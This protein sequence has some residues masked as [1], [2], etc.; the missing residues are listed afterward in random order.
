VTQSDA[1]DAPPA[2]GDAVDR[3]LSATPIALV[4]M[5]GLFPQAH[6]VRDY[7]QNVVDATDCTS[8]VPADRWK[9]ED[10]WDPDPA[11][12]DKTYSRRG[13]FL[14]EVDFDPLEFGLPPN[15]LE[16]TSTLQTLSLGVARDVLCDAGAP[17]SSWYDPS[18]TGVVLGVTGPVPLMHPLAAR[19]ST[20]VLEEVV[21]SC[22]LTDDDAQTISAKYVKAFAPWVE[23][24]FPGLLA[25]VVAGRVANRLG[26]GGMNS[27]VDAACA[28][29][30]SAT[31]V[32]IAELVDR[33]AD[34]MITGGCD[35]ENSIFIYLCFSKVGAL[36]HHDRIRPFDTSADGTLLG[37][38]IGMLAL[39]RLADAERDGDRVY[40]VIRGLGSSS[41]GRATSIY[42]PRAEGQRLALDRAYADAD[43]SPASV[44][45]FEAHA[46]GTLV[47]DRTELTALGGLLR[48]H[49][50]EDRFAAIGSVKSQIGH[51]KGA[52]G[53]ASMM[54]LALGLYHKTLPPTIGVEEPN[55]ALATTDAPL[56]AN[57]R[58]RPWILDPQRP[59]RRAGASAMGFG[60]TNFHLVLEEATGDRATVRTLHRTAR[61]HAWHAATAAELRAQLAAG[62]R[63][64]DAATIPAGHA[65]L[66]F[67][68]VDAEDE[69]ELRALA[70][71][72]LDAADGDAPWSHPRGVWFRPRA[73]DDLRVGAVFA[74]QGSQYLDMG[75][76]AA[77]NNPTVAGAFD[78]ANASFA[79]AGRRLGAVVFPPPVFDA[80]TRRGQESAL[81]RTEYAQPA[82]GALAVGQ[83]RFLRDRGLECSAMLGHS[84]GE[85]TALWAAG[86][87]T[88][89]DFFRLARARGAAMAPANDTSDGD[90]PD[91]GSMAAVSADR[92]RV[93][94]LLAELGVDDVAVCN[95]NA[96][97]QVVVGGGTD[98]VDRVVAA[99]GER[100]IGVKNV[101]VA[102][103]FH[104]PH[105]AHAVARFRPVV[106]AVEVAEPRTPVIADAAGA[107]YGS[108]VAC[109]RD[110]LAGQLLEPVEFVAGLTELAEKGCTVI[111]EF[112]PKQVL[113]QLV[114]R[115]LG[116]AVIAV[117]TDAGPIGDSDLALKQAA[118]QLAVLGAPLTGIGRDDAPDREPAAPHGMTVGLTAAEYVP[119][120]RAEA[121][122]AALADT[123]PLEALSAAVPAATS[124]PAPPVP[125]VVAAVRTEP[126]PGSALATRSG[127]GAPASCAPASG[128]PAVAAPPRASSPT[129]VA[130]R[131]DDVLA[132]HTALHG[133]YLDGQLAIA[134]RLVDV[135]EQR[136]DDPRAAAVAQAVAAQSVA[137]SETHTRAN[138]VLASL[139][140]LGATPSRSR[141]TAEA[142]R[143]HR[144][145][146][147]T[148]ATELS[149]RSDVATGP[150]SG[151]VARESDTRTNGHH[152]SAVVAPPTPSDE[153][154]PDGL[155]PDALRRVLVEVVADKTGYPAGMVDPGL[156]LEADLGVDS[157]KRVQVLGAVQER[158]PQL[159]A[160]GPES[161]AELRTLDQ[162]VAHLAASAPQSSAPQSSAPPSSVPGAPAPAAPTP[163]APD[164]FDPDALRRVLVE[165]VAD[166]T[167]YPAGMVDPGLDL[168]ADL[169]VDSI[170]RVQVLGAVQERYPQLPAVGPESLA[171]L[172]TLDQIVA[173]LAA[174]PAGPHGAGPAPTGPDDDA[175]P[176]R[177]AIDLVALPDRDDLD[178]PFAVDPVAVVVD[179]GGPE[180]DALAT[181]L[182]AA[183][184]RVRRVTL[185]GTAGTDRFGAAMPA[186]EADSLA[187]S[188]AEHLDGALGGTDR[189][190]ACLLVLRDEEDLGSSLSQLCDAV[191]VAGHAQEALAGT[192][193]GGT[194]AAF[195]TV[196]RCDGGLGLRGRL[197]ADDAVLAG[198]GGLAKTM[199]REAP[200]VFSR[201][202][203][204]APVLDADTAAALVVGELADAALDTPEVGIDADGRRWTIAVGGTARP[205][206]DRE[207]AVGPDD[208]VLVTGGARGV[209]A[210]C[211]RGL[212]ERTHA[213]FV[214]LGRTELTDEPAWAT[215]VADADLQSAVIG[216]LSAD[217]ARPSPRDVAR[218]RDDL[219]AQREV[220]ATLEAVRAAG[221]RVRYVTVDVTDA[222]AVRSSLSGE[223]TRA[224]VLV[225]GAGALADGLLPV[226]T[227]PGVHRVLAAKLA[228]LHHVLAAVPDAPLREVVLFGSVAGVFGNP[229]QSDYALANEALARWAASMRSAR[230]DRRIRTLAWGAWDGGMVDADL[231]ELFLARG[232]AL[233]DPADG[234][235]LFVDSFGDDESGWFLVGERAPLAGP[236]AAVAA[237]E[238]TVHRD[239]G[240]LRDDPVLAAHRIG[241]DVVLPATVALGWMVNTAERTRPG[242]HVVAVRDL[243][244]QRGLV[245][246]DGPTELALTLTP[247]ADGVRAE[248]RGDGP[249][250][251]YAASLV[252]TEDTA[253]VGPPE[254]RTDWPTDRVGHGPEDGADLYR[255]G[256][257]FHG[258][259]L[260]GM[261]RVLD[262]RD[263]RIVVECAIDAGVLA[264]GAYRGRHHD[265][266]LADLVLQVPPVLGA[267]VLGSACLP[268]GIGRMDVLA[269]LPADGPFVVIA[270]H[271][272][273]GPTSLRCDVTVCTPDGRVLQRWSDVD[274]VTTPDLD[275]KFAHAVEAWSGAAAITSGAQR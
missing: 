104:T 172:R 205:A 5:A 184:W 30:L 158:Y 272:R 237:G 7:W 37:E 75:L 98:Q 192:A 166:K 45:L 245:F 202:I 132:Q 252:L 8:E 167:G 266:V 154:A 217:G 78:E 120:E 26:L 173:H 72:Q 67:A 32:A 223:S 85:L 188:L 228:G 256:V 103:A 59:R 15:Q 242:T 191:L 13:G 62:E 64:A 4:G 183:G 68:S 226:K 89:A 129:E 102:A 156:D 112:G 117:P 51:T 275:A 268:L 210:L 24:S 220:R 185:P 149:A 31:R 144:V 96:P 119:A 74:G 47:G 76:E 99:C 155:D 240:R 79:D 38:G 248:V 215:E 9:V 194:R 235:R 147:P 108:D 159:P 114:R 162:I 211:V 209:T 168:E 6:D 133:R 267:R 77:L 236:P 274:V 171:E 39:K 52:A 125:E 134:S 241:D 238:V 83:F 107:S 257:Q 42:A 244:V 152:E 200:E 247:I 130:G 146:V 212:A 213:E 160:V 221:S 22:G 265:P 206:P 43:C 127:S 1:P 70:L 175:G 186:G 243:A 40:A 201:A 273:S 271:G 86:S 193:R 49:S 14:P 82:I 48:E 255:R 116:D 178:A 145:D 66:G 207:P 121:Y 234:V 224:T 216:A 36:S 57:T 50:D 27:T 264:R 142:V 113:T 219:L 143:E 88:D 44:E 164:G 222:A 218:T 60:G 259:A 137:I 94:A 190:D 23:N 34:M 16:V 180:P 153:P 208:V 138:E 41:D 231:R 10:Y 101:P 3:R 106:D 174:D 91:P 92:E 93:T 135:W 87:L 97:D 189:V 181:A 232:V 196:T 33:R 182:G 58:T 81:R 123:R 262:A 249:A 12:A 80:E 260:Q 253:P 95:H 20:P 19:L 254:F 214:L 204:V 227:A 250:T 84:F 270:D 150:T 198:V 197:I 46:T 115:T 141:V 157:I 54:K 35:T 53:T 25:N 179:R 100:G 118:V 239:L 161:L 199:A 29:S 148:A 128:S 170:K 165:V 90:T 69:A 61:A 109:N 261:R 233:L 151:P 203:D 73:L 195:V 105:V 55:E 28:A 176:A 169:G 163:S 229:G 11:A 131:E 177:Y 63:P 110:V 230:P 111:V 251:R 136:G 18:R 21:R 263:D 65:R 269:P 258:P 140:G 187:D 225:H 71:E 126:T 56:Y 139:A 2:V 246:G 17:G 122:R 124:A